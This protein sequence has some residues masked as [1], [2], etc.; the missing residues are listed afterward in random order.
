VEN[1]PTI[2]PA[3][4]VT[5]NGAS[6]TTDPTYNVRM[7]MEANNAALKE[8]T[9]VKVQHV[10]ETQ[11]LHVMYQEKLTLAEAK[12]IDAILSANV[13]AQQTDRE[14]ASAQAQVLANQVASSAETLRLLV[15]STATAQAASQSQTTGQ[16]NDRISQLEKAQYTTVGKAAV[17]DPM[18]ATLVQKMEIVISTLSKTEGKGIGSNA[19]WGYIVGGAGLLAIVLKVLNIY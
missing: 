1:D 16:L 12:R 13:S 15:A 9:E 5:R 2:N 17:A 18:L 10:E 11:R 4:P 6:A 19:L 14:R 7:L 8:L 3:G